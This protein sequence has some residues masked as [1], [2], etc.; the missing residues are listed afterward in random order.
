MNG[1]AT[2]PSYELRETGRPPKEEGT[3]SLGIWIIEIPLA[4]EQDL[5]EY[6]R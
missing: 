6:V 3:L 2:Q 5:F 4:N 1:T